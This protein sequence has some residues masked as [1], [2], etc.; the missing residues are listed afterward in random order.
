MF[1]LRVFHHYDVVTFVIHILSS[2]LP[3]GGEHVASCGIA[4]GAELYSALMSLAEDVR[5]VVGDARTQEF[6]HSLLTCPQ[7][8][9]FHFG[10]NR[11]H[12]LLLFLPVHRALYKGWLERTYALYVQPARLFAHHTAHS[13]AAMAHAEVQARTFRQSGF[14]V[15]VTLKTR[16]LHSLTT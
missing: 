7:A 6:E 13:Q 5:E 3:G 14:A 9:E 4:D 16:F 12:Y 1:T 11:G 10:T 15:S 8:D 2:V